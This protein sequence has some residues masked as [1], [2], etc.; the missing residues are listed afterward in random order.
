MKDGKIIDC[1]S[2]LEPG[3]GVCPTHNLL[4]TGDGVPALKWGSTN[5]YT[6]DADGNPVYNWKLTDSIF[7][8]YVQ[9]GMKPLVEIGFMLKPYPAI[10]FRID[11]I[12]NR[13]INMPT[14]YRI[15][16]RRKIIKMGR[17]HPSMGIA[18]C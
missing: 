14:F 2:C 13:E 10:H 3:P 11:T 4:T 5:A 17:T 8:T 12:G 16:I 9:R 6:E 7:D 18:L 15:F 1:V